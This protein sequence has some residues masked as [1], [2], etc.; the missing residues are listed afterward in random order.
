MRLSSAGAIALGLACSILCP[1]GVHGQDRVRG[2]APRSSFEEARQLTWRSETRQAG[3]AKLRE[4]AV[5]APSDSETQFELGRVLTWDPR[6]R[7]EGITILRRVLEVRPHDIATTEA[8]AEVLAWDAGTRT[9]AV[10]LLRLVLDEQPNRVSARLKLAEVLSWN[11]DTRE[12]ARSSYLKVLAE[13]PES[14]EASVGLARTLSWSGRMTESRRWYHAVLSRDPSVE[15]ARV[16]SAELDQWDGRPL[17]SLRTL[18]RSGAPLDTPDAVR[19]RA[20][21]YSRL[22]RNARA[23]AEYDRVL[24]LDP[25]NNT[26]LMASRRIRDGLRPTFEIGTEASTASGT[27]FTELDG[28]SIPFRVGFHPHGDME[29]SLTGARETYRNGFGTTRRNA[30]GAGLEGPLGNRV[31]I[32]TGAT[33]HDIDNV[34]P[35]VV[36]RAKLQL[37][38]NDRLSVRLGG[39]R[40]HVAASRMCV[41]GELINDTTYGPCFVTQGIAGVSLQRHGWDGWAQGTAGVIRGRHLARNDRQELFAGAGKS[42]RIGSGSLR[43]GYGL[44]AISYRNSAEQFPASTGQADAA[45]TSGYFSPRLFTNH[46][47]RADLTLPMG[48]ALVVDT[49]FGI[50]RQ[51][52]KEDRYYTA[53]PVRSS[54]AHV[55]I[56][57]PGSGRVSIY[58]QLSRDNV[59]DA[60]NRTVARVQLIS[61]F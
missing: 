39:A 29:V 6:T 44:T 41:A 2:D 46:M 34:R 13:Q 45:V 10:S 28:L 57:I 54:D 51:R 31:R 52:V 3:I 33:V 18:S 53:P 8:L 61:A 5:T 25:Q 21:A 30:V 42:V 49:G 59:A 24:A 35:Q 47:G 20:D 40:E 4:L 19:V 50:G 16:G 55:G 22:G 37:A 56:K 23:L 12:E 7:G 26:A 58:A 38:L 11:P 17:A 48:S 43:I 15:A 32:S 1:A 60:Y 27:A 9:E 36:G 14:I